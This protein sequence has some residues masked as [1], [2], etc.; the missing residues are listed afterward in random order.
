MINH[1]QV[2]LVEAAPIGDYFASLDKIIQGNN[3]VLQEEPEE[4]ID[5]RCETR[6]PRFLLPLE[7]RPI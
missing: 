6:N 4:N 2:I 1:F 5:F 7:K 3:F